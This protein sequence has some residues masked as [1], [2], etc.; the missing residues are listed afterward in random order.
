M[1]KHTANK[2]LP[3]A[4]SYV[5]RFV[6]SKITCFSNRTLYQTQK[7]YNKNMQASIQHKNY[8]KKEAKEERVLISLV[9]FT[10]ADPRGRN[11]LV[12]PITA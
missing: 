9:R 7:L 10:V 2:H 8:H 3:P 12:H 5:K 6:P 4:V 11:P 1:C